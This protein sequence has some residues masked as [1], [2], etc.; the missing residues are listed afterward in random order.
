MLFAPI[1]GTTFLPKTMKHHT[2]EPGR[3]R[4]I[5]HRILLMA[6]RMKWI[7]I[8]ITLV[9]FALAMFGMGFVQKQFFPTSDRPELIIDVTQ[10][11][12]S[13]IQ[14]T[15][16]VMA[17]LDDWLSKQEEAQFW[18]TYVGR[19]APRFI[20]ALDVPAPGPNM[21]QIVIMTES[22]EARDKL[23]AKANE[24]SLIHI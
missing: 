22:L 5:F 1:L 4:K 14:S 8:G 13:T 12:N 6:M 20:L 9:V 2:G 17:K 24:L 7:A 18:T 21:G 23:K 10:R 15:D 19:T 3:V 16:A 11:Q